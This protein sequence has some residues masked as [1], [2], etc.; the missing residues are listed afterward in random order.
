MFNRIEYFLEEHN[1]IYELQF[2]FRNFFLT[3]HA[4]LSIVESIRTNLDNKSFSCGV[5][6]DLEK[7]FD[8]VNHTILLSKLS[9]Y[10]IRGT[11]LEWFRSYLTNRKQCT[12]TNGFESN[13]LSINCGVPQAQSL[14]PYVF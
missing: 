5:F 12:T 8:T 10:G 7:A 14:D 9:H 4:L 11:S 3:N 13:Y 2:G 1:S 6:V